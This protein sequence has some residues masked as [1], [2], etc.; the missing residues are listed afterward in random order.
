MNTTKRN[1][2]AIVVTILWPLILIML[3]APWDAPAPGGGYSPDTYGVPT[4]KDRLEQFFWLGV[5]PLLAYWGF[6]F[7]RGAKTEDG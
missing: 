1:R 2:I 5:L 3:L 4:S 7:V 6:V